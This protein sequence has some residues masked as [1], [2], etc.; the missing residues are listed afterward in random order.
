[1]GSLTAI[2][3]VQNRLFDHRT[4]QITITLYTIQSPIKLLILAG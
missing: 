1:M 3:R 4:D 2:F